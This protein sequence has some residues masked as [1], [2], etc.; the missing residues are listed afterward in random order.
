M[1]IHIPL[2]SLRDLPAADKVKLPISLTRTDDGIEIVVSRYEDPVWDFWPYITQGNRGPA[3]KVLDWR[4][5]LGDGTLLTDPRNSDLLASI[6]D[7]I[8]SLVIDPVEGRQRPAMSTI[9]NIS[10]AAIPLLRWMVEQGIRSFGALKGRTLEYVP[11]ARMSDKTGAALSKGW[12]SRR[13]MILEDLYSQR[14]KLADGL[15]MHPWP[16]ESA[17]ILAGDRSKGRTPKT[18]RIPERTVRRLAE[19]AIDYVETQADRLLAARDAIEQVVNGQDGFRA[20]NIRVPMARDFGFAGSRELQTELAALRHSCYVVIALF[21]GIRDS[22]ILGLE[23]GCIAHTRTNDGIDLT[24]MHGTIYK[25]GVRPHRWLVPPI[26]EKAVRV[27]ERYRVPYAAKMDQQIA[28]DEAKIVGAVAH[29]EAHKRLVKRLQVARRDRNAL[30]LAITPRTG[31]SVGIIRGSKI[32]EYLKKYCQRFGVLGDDGVPWGLHPHQFRRTYAYFVAS[33]EL[34][35]LQYLRE[36]FGHW[37]IDMTLLYCDGATDEF[38]TD[39]DLLNE[40]LRVKAE[41][42]EGVLRSY[43]LDDVPLANG[44]ALLADLR[45]M[46]KTARNRDELIRQVSDGI[47]LNGTGHSWCIGSAKGSNCGGL[48]VFEADMCVDCS[49]GMIGPEHLPVWKE[50]A[51]QQREALAM[52]DLGV[53]GKARSER[54]LRKAEAVVAQL[55]AR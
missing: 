5:E 35:D 45:R 24:W 16:G 10:R 14:Y 42:Q 26:V 52:S 28:A 12:Y 22:E 41:K 11:V 51:Q 9:I 15:V 54:I 40:I 39:A 21:S 46:V 50:I 29:S 30:F 34:G 2:R 3:D 48:C 25:T 32:G 17:F 6:K 7:F 47:T 18:K 37:S 13:L 44:D 27:M 23:R 38:D 53:P 31:H 8:W 20:T 4:I 1:S 36:H 33:A 55:E 43:L 49:Y 19:I